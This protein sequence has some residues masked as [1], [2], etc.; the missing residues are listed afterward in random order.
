MCGQMHRNYQHV[1]GKNVNFL[2]PSFYTAVTTFQQ[3]WEEKCVEGI[4]LKIRR[5]GKEGILRSYQT[6]S[7]SAYKQLICLKVRPFLI[8]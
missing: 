1:I 3:S 7:I 2:C 5:L 8:S 6:K 4:H